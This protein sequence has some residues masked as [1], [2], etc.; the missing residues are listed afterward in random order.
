[1]TTC[2]DMNKT[3]INSK[4]I[5]HYNFKSIRA[6]LGRAW[7]LLR[8]LILDSITMMAILVLRPHCDDMRKPT[9]TFGLQQMIRSQRQSHARVVWYHASYRARFPAYHC[10]PSQ[11][12]NKGIPEPNIT[13]AG[14]AS[15]QHFS[16][17]HIFCCNLY[18]QLEWGPYR[19]Q[20]S[21][22]KDWPEGIHRAWSP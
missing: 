1:M 7:I 18:A 21:Q 11:Q 12:K 17:S 13:A 14:D 9:R 2:R 4:H 20:M 8:R 22:K 6:L 16:P 5:R 3:F 10:L 19:P 15:I